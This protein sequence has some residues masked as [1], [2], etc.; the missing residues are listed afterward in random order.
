MPQLRLVEKPFPGSIVALTGR[1]D[2]ES[3]EQPA[4]LVSSL[5]RLE[6]I[7]NARYGC[8]DSLL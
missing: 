2:S 7:M 1:P 6:A 5:S 3:Q 4:P 8:F